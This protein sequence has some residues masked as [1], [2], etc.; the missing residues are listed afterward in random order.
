MKSLRIKQGETFLLSGQY[1]NDDG[2]PKSLVGVTLLSQV[3]DRFSFVETLVVTIANAAGGL[4]EISSTGSTL[5]WP[6]GELQWDIK[7]VAG[8][9]ERLTDT[10]KIVVQAA[11]TRL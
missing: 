9:V 1:L 2:T 3:R 8:G 11:V 10:Y 5:N 4:Y 7:E 6:V